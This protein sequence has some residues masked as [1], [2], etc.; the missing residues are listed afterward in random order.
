[1]DRDDGVHEKVEVQPR[2]GDRIPVRLRV[3]SLGV[4]GERTRP[5]DASLDGE[6][7]EEDG[8]GGL[9]DRIHPEP[10]DRGIESEGCNGPED[11]CRIQIGGLSSSPQEGGVDL[12]RTF[13]EGVDPERTVDKVDDVGVYRDLEQAREVSKKDGV[14]AEAGPDEGSNG[15]GRDRLQDLPRR[16]RE[17]AVLRDPDRRGDEEIRANESV[18]RE[19]SVARV[20]E[21]RADAEGP[22]NAPDQH[23]IERD[24]GSN[25]GPDSERAR[26]LADDPRG[27]WELALDPRI[28]PE[29]ARSHESIDPE[30]GLDER[31]DR[32]CRHHASTLGRLDREVESE[33][34]AE[35][36]VDGEARLDEGADGEL[37]RRHSPVLVE[38]SSTQGW[39][40]GVVL[41]G[42]DEV[43]AGGRSH[44]MLASSD[45]NGIAAT[46]GPRDP[47]IPAVAGRRDHH[48]D[49]LLARVDREG[50]RQ[51]VDGEA[52]TR[53]A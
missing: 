52:A 49:R 44:V 37:E 17:R 31:A 25:E 38:A 35:A 32:E 28:E 24:G 5:V 47:E 1:M 22:L 16:D 26:D 2:L 29:A 40:V 12:H 43:L 53:P 14:D 27:Y 7:E 46:D 21:P 51:D 19:G 11:N 15:E 8:L 33:G 3:P 20:Y 41:R 42:G 9:E 36:S 10:R 45:R 50:G 48:H 4:D 23:R 39:A 6:Q 30:V 18:N 34:P 13:D